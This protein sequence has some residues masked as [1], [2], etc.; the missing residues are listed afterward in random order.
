MRAWALIGAAGLASSLL[1]ASLFTVIGGIPYPLMNLAIALTHGA[2]IGTLGGLIVLP[3]RGR[4]DRRRPLRRS[5]ALTVTLLVVAVGG[6]MI[7]DLIVTTIGLVPRSLYWRMAVLD[8]WIGIV[9]TLAAGGG[10]LLYE[11]TRERLDRATLEL[12]ESQLAALS[13]RLHPHF[14]FNTL[15]A[16]RVLVRDDPAHAERL[17]DRLASLLRAALDTSDRATVPLGEELQ[18]VQSYLEI[19]AARLGPRFAATIE[20][21][22]E[23]SLV[24]VPPLCLQTLAENAVKHVAAARVGGACLRVSARRVDGGVEL[25]V[26]DDGPPFAIDAPAPG[27]GLHTLLGR[28][29]SLYRGAARL[30]VIAGDGGKTVTVW[31]PT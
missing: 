7:A 27:H 17:I 4:L 5:I 25:S 13:A 10:L 9:T 15:N 14:L 8:V 21:A 2:V 6:S 3:L 16:I 28:L 23:L 12:R 30:D 18:L 22:T 26:W 20:V 19:E 1:I 24:P 29:R 31:L 11:S